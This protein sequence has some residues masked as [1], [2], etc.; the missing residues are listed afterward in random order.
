LGANILQL[1]YLFLVIVVFV[2]AQHGVRAENPTREKCTCNLELDDPPSDGAWVKNATACWS[3]EVKQ[4][5][6][7]DIVV[8]SLDGPQGSQ[9][10]TPELFGSV[11]NL[12]VLLDVIRE[13]FDNFVTVS[14]AEGSVID[15]NFAAT[16]VSARLKMNGELIAE[17][18]TALAEQRRGFV[19][20]GEDGVVCRISDASG[21][22]RLEIPVESARIVYMIAPAT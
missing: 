11:T 1:R 18:V 20:D 2:S 14:T 5:N 15:F 8:E 17:C 3:T 19:R 7:C 6:W 16:T 10:A 4:R 9:T 22:M 12:P 21:W 13:R